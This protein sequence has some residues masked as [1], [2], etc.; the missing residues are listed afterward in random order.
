[1]SGFAEWPLFLTDKLVSPAFAVRLLTLGVFENLRP[2][3]LDRVSAEVLEANSNLSSCITF[4]FSFV[5]AYNY[6]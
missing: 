3:L 5:L 1:M 2:V 4:I 6:K